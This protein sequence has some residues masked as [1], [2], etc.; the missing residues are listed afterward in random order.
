[1]QANGGDGEV[2]CGTGWES[3]DDDSL[4]VLTDSDSGAETGL[5]F[6][7]GSYFELVFGYWVFS[8]YLSTL[9]L[10]VYS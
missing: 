10:S 6:S 2:L 4:P 1:V 8:M 9:V 5:D 7:L 3:D